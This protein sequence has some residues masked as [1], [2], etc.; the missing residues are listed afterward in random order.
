MQ[1]LDSKST[2]PLPK[3]QSLF[4]QE[5]KQLGASPDQIQVAIGILSSD[6]CVPIN[7]DCIL[8][9]HKVILTEASYKN[10]SELLISKINSKEALNIKGDHLP[11]P[12]ELVDIYKKNF[13][14]SDL[15]ELSKNRADLY[16][17][18]INRGLQ[19]NGSISP[20]V[21][22]PEMAI[23]FEKLET[24]F[25][26]LKKAVNINPQ[27]VKDFFK[28]FGFTE[29]SDIDT[30]SQ[31]FTKNINSL[32]TF[33]DEIL[34]KVKNK[35]WDG[36]EYMDLINFYNG[37]YYYLNFEDITYMAENTLTPAEK[38]E[39]FRELSQTYSV[40]MFK[41]SIEQSLRIG[42]ISLISTE[43]LKEFTPF[44]SQM[45][46]P[47]DNLEL[48]NVFMRRFDNQI[49]YSSDLNKHDKSHSTLIEDRKMQSPASLYLSNIPQPPPTLATMKGAIK[50]KL[51]SALMNLQKINILL[52][53]LSPSDQKVFRTFI[54]H[55]FHETS[56]NN[57]I[58]NEYSLDKVL[59]LYMV[60][61]YM[62]D[63]NLDK[64]TELLN[65]D[66][67]FNFNNSNYSSFRSNLSRY[68]L[69][70]SD[71]E[72]FTETLKSL[73]KEDSNIFKKTSDVI[74]R[75]FTKYFKRK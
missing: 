3:R 53:Q 62:H 13:A 38:E 75:T 59:K 67:K 37:F 21:A 29:E 11:I 23:V 24:E 26:L 47:I 41:I 52:N 25:L 71:V 48:P 14:P 50:K 17:K 46:V 58:H 40:F 72:H 36:L 63:G 20:Q 39:L 69:N 32:S 8:K 27:G 15:Y 68:N 45:A 49:H 43:S 65:N 74:I 28:T 55:C 73:Q 57:L 60:D 10:F 54:F 16:W 22:V 33:Y 1:S 30:I 2:I 4:T 70:Q 12:S 18:I 31:I 6:L 64:V 9:I 35:G 34:S 61:L 19:P 44:L 7:K 66:S 51:D 56:S 5:L 42:E